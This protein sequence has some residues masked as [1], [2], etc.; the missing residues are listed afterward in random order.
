MWHT[1][2]KMIGKQNH[3]QMIEDHSAAIETL[4]N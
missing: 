3:M 2:C 1:Q 4:G